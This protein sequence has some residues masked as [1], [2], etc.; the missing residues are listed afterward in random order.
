MAV[1]SVSPGYICRSQWDG[2]PTRDP[3]DCRSILPACRFPIWFVVLRRRDV[4]FCSNMR[5]RNLRSFFFAH[6]HNNPSIT[7]V[8]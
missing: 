6:L 3:A 2:S 5:F 7:P 8:D 1:P 4:L